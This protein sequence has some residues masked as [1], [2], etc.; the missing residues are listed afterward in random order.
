MSQEKLQLKN[1]HNICIENLTKTN[2]GFLAILTGP[3]HFEQEKKE[4]YFFIKR[5]CKINFWVF[6]KNYDFLDFENWPL[7]KKNYIFG[8][9]IIDYE[10][11]YFEELKKNLPKKKMRNTIESFF[12]QKSENFENLKNSKNENFSKSRKIT[13]KNFLQILPEFNFKKKK[14]NLEGILLRPSL[15]L[16]TSLNS[17]QK[18]SLKIS[19]INFGKI[20]LGEKKMKKIFITNNSQISTKFKI[21]QKK[22]FLKKKNFC[23]KKNEIENLKSEDLPENFIFDKTEGI[24]KKDATFFEVIPESDFVMAGGEKIGNK[25]FEVKILFRPRKEGFFKSCYKI[26]EIFGSCICFV[27]KGEGIIKKK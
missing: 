11:Y 10:K 21:I 17:P 27:L 15:T 18:S 26:V 9:L 23:L 6:M 25:V 1:K 19:S 14:I 22:I 4:K 5:N 20:F 7:T 16:L 24:L 13:S 12:E 3:F 8:N 2:I